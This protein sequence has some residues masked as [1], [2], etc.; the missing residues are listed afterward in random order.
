MAVGFYG[1]VTL[2]AI[3]YAMFSSSLSS[4]FGERSPTGKD[5]M[6]GVGFGLVLVLLC[7][8]ADA[9][10]PAVERAGEALSALLGPVTMLQAVV[11]ALASGFAEELLFRG[12]LWR[13][14]GLAGTSLLFGLVHTLPRR[15]LVLYPVFAA[16]VGL[17]LGLVRSGTETV[18]PCM[19][20]HAVVNGLNLTWLERRRRRVAGA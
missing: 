6:W 7:R 20:A 4:L 1:V 3:G 17:L 15:A 11:L 10:S 12:A 19:V 16:V 14:L 8:F 18:V 5:W 2:F 13:H 9:M